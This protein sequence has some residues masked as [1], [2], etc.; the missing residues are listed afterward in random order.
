MSDE[1][2]D[3]VKL[4]AMLAWAELDILMKKI[5]FPDQSL[6]KHIHVLKPPA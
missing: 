3:G 2:D 4:H 6:T 5:L 1:K